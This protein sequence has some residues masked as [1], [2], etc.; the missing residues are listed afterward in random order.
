MS[1]YWW[2]IEV[3]DGGAFPAGRWKD[4]H[5]AS[6]IEAALSRGAKDWNWHEHHWGVI[7]EVA[8]ADSADW[9]GYRQLPAVV[10]ALDAVPDPINGLLIYQGRG[11][12]SSSGEHRRPRPKQG[13]GAA[14]VPAEPSPIVVAKTDAVSEALVAAASG[15]PALAAAA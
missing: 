15:T 5:G 6:L 1:E 12:S 7:F 10:A 14:P 4:A 2:S 11:G 8:F 9:A 3:L 13:G